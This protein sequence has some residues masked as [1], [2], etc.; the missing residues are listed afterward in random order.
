MDNITYD[1]YK[2][3]S[4]REKINIDSL[5]TSNVPETEKTFFLQKNSTFLWTLNNLKYYYIRDNE[6]DDFSTLENQ[7]LK[8]SSKEKLN[9]NDHNQ[10][11]KNIDN[12]QDLIYNPYIREM[13][14][15]QKLIKPYK[16][17][18]NDNINKYF[19]N[20][21]EKVITQDI[22]SIH[23]ALMVLGLFDFK[24][25][26]TNEKRIILDVL[27][28]NKHEFFVPVGYLFD[29]TKIKYGSWKELWA[30]I[31]NYDFT[32]DENDNLLLYTKF[33]CINADYFDERINMS[34]FPHLPSIYDEDDFTDT[35][36]FLNS[37][38]WS[39]ELYDYELDFI[40]AANMDNYNKKQYQEIKDR[41][42]VLRFT[43]K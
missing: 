2:N 23:D 4:E 1:F 26:N 16:P 22:V 27:D 14:I 25:F 6:L 18:T 28:F 5:L 36:T 33:F 40:L 19:I 3:L 34:F 20:L 38:D 32:Y 21:Q 37:I 41:I 29:D 8:L 43:N 13:L 30:K 7:L 15:K 9:K 39:Q 10:L 35:K 12:L 11:I 24:D 31:S 42:K 17:T